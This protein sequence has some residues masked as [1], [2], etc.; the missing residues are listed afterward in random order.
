MTSEILC[1][2][3]EKTPVLAAGGRLEPTAGEVVDSM[4]ASLSEN[5]WAWA[6]G[7][8]FLLWVPVCFLGLPSSRPSLGAGV[9]MIH[10]DIFHLCL[11][12]DDISFLGGIDP[13]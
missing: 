4:P 10:P 12:D 1:Q 3:R 7:E 9:E 5:L 13:G 2:L 8:V 11:F 6:W